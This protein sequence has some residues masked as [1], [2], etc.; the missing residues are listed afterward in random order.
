MSFSPARTDLALKLLIKKHL[1]AKDALYPG[2]KDFFHQIPKF[3]HL[4]SID[5]KNVLIG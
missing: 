5:V 3:L 4:K 2:L 1:H